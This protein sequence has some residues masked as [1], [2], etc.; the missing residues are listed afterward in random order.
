[1]SPVRGLG[2]RV[3]VITGYRVRSVV[4]Q[5]A[6]I[7]SLFDIRVKCLEESLDFLSEHDVHMVR[8]NKA[9]L[10]ACVKPSVCFVASCFSFSSLPPLGRYY[11]LQELKTQD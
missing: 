9:L 6:M 3:Q 8:L 4:E 11:G 1:M 2:S 7:S 5:R 10:Y